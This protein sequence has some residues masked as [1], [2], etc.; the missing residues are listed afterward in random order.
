MCQLSLQS[1][2]QKEVEERLKRVDVEQESKREGLAELHRQTLAEE[3][4]LADTMRNV[5][6]RKVR[7]TNVFVSRCLHD[8]V[9]CLCRYYSL[10]LSLKK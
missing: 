9:T 6:G 7:K 10:W 1:D 3:E 4:R 5:I 2:L 8:A